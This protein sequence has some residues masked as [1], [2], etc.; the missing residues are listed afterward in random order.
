MQNILQ[1]GKDEEDLDE[2]ISKVKEYF[3]AA[4]YTKCLD[5]LQTKLVVCSNI[6][7]A[8]RW[9]PKASYVKRK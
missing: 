1:A 9:T 4:S 3:K 8:F 5:F 7:T 6:L 2:Q